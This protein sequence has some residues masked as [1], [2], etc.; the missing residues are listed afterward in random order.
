MSCVEV[1]AEAYTVTG[2]V[3]FGAGATINLTG[4]AAF[5][6]EEL[7]ALKLVI[8][9]AGAYGG[10]D[11]VTVTGDVAFTPGTLPRLVARMNG[12]LVVPFGRK[13]LMLI[14]R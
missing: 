12:D 3:S 5:T 8:A 1:F 10:L 2:T 6:D 13:G 4:L 9:K 11:N 14:F 7:Q